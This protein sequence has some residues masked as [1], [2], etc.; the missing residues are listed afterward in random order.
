MFVLGIILLLVAVGVLV[1]VLS[2]GSNQPA[3]FDLGLVAIQTNTLG[4]FLLGAA[5]VL[6]LVVGLMLLVAGIRR[7]RR[8]RQ[9]RKK[10]NRLTEQLET[11]EGAASSTDE[12]TSTAVATTPSGAEPAES[13]ETG[14]SPET[15]A[16]TENPTAQTPTTQTPTTQTE[17]PVNGPTHRAP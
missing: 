8:R 4:V 5:T 13:A 2:G 15:K 11:R 17:K 12:G 3:T 14:S 7:G 6:L 9:E 16:V 1:A 10:L